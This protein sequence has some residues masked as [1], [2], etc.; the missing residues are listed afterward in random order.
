MTTKKQA[1]KHLTIR[2]LTIYDLEQVDKL[3]DNGFPKNERATIEKLKYRLT[4]CPELTSGLFIREFIPKFQK[5]IDRS[6]NGGKRGTTEETEEEEDADKDGDDDEDDDDDDDES[7]THN[8][9]LPPSKSTILKETLIGHIIAA[10]CYD[11]HITDRSMEIPKL[12]QDFLPDLTIEGNDK[13]GHVESSRYIGIHSIVINENYRGLKLGLLLIKD[14]LQKMNQQ[15]I[16]DKIVIIAKD[17]LVNFY[18]S[19][20]FIDEGISNCKFGGEEWHDLY[21]PLNHDEDDNDM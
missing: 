12:T 15:D 19:L 2:P 17:K 9:Y 3:E 1:P 20:E 21:Y 13:I 16:A 11:E 6:E 7:K 10:K 18:E 4:V 8:G 5:A 14:Y